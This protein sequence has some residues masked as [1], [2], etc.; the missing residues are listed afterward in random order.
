MS[1]VGEHG[2]DGDRLLV[3]EFALGLLD[4]QEHGRMARRIAADPALGRELA[5]WRTR[6]SSLDSEFAEAPAPAGVLAKIERRLFT[7]NA[8]ARAAFWDSLLFWRGL[9]AAGLAVALLAIG[10]NIY[11]PRAPLTGQELVAAL[12]QEGSGVK[13]VAFYDETSGKV[14]LAALSGS[15]VP[16]K[17]FELWAIKGSNAPVSMGV[18]PV[19][20]R[21][22]VSLSAALKTGFGAGTVLAVTLEQKGGSPTGAPQGPIV[23]KG[24][25]IPI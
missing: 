6:L 8:P 4:A 10:Y 11:A 24:A 25:A 1:S 2:E 23:A 5:L 22:E 7:T 14:R 17:D 18:I 12:E 16:N 19:D 20:A 3:A 9:A 21:S 15:A 13:F